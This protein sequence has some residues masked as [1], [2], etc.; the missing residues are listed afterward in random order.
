[1]TTMTLAKFVRQGQGMR[2]FYM[3]VC[4]FLTLFF[5]TNILIKLSAV[6]KIDVR[7]TYT[8]IVRTKFDKTA[9]SCMCKNNI[10]NHSTFCQ[11]Y[12]E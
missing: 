11:D 3:Q 4:K 9:P 2:N 1:M 8:K 5:A 6:R 7:K 10:E 12:L